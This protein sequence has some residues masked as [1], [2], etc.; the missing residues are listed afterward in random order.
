MILDKAQ[1]LTR[2]PLATSGGPKKKSLSAFFSKAPLDDSLPAL[3]HFSSTP[4]FKL[5]KH[6][7]K[8]VHLLKKKD[9]ENIVPLVNYFISQSG[10]VAY[11]GGDAVA[12]LYL[13]GK[14]KYKS[15]NLLAIVTSSDVDK[16][17]Y[18]MNNIISSND[19]EFSMGFKYRVRKNRCE[20][21]F[22]DIAQARYF[23]EPRLVGP[24]KLLYLFRPSTIEL[25]ITTQEQFAHAFGIDE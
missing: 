1:D 23:I 14:R 21:C 7:E 25:D 22:K 18:L 13:H 24:E 10:H 5:E 15:L 8:Y 19:G 11:L 20:G 16:Y 9:R 3:I 6:P 12:N 4:L 17:S 2:R